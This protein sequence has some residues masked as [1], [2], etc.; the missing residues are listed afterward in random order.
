MINKL[1]Y[2]YR[3]DVLLSHERKEMDG[4]S[5]SGRGPAPEEQFHLSTLRS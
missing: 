1:R 4:A 2:G 3:T 5:L